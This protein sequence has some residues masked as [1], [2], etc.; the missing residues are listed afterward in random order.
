MRDRLYVHL[1]HLEFVTITLRQHLCTQKDGHTT[2]C[3]RNGCPNEEQPEEQEDHAVHDERTKQTY[4][5]F[6]SMF[7]V[8]VC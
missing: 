6:F 3:L 5:F 2:L 4:Q 8:H 7:V 1:G